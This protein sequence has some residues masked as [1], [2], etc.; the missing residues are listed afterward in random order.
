MGKLVFILAMFSSV[1]AFA[2]T[3]K[4][5]YGIAGSALGTVTLQ[6]DDSGNVGPTADVAMFFT[7]T[8]QLPVTQYKAQAGEYLRLILAEAD[9]NNE[10][11]LTVFAG[12]GLPLKSKLVNPAAPPM[13]KEL[14][15]SCQ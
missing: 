10:M 13:A 4:C 11:H 7:G 2:G 8:R 3:L 14:A 12:T 15:G 9:P 1:A 5:E 6:V